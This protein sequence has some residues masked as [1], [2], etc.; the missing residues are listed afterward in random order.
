MF[1]K[2]QLKSL[3]VATALI[4]LNIAVMWI[5][6]FT[7]LAAIN[8][9]LFGS[10]FLLGVL[11]YGAMLTGGVH[12]AKKGVRNQNSSLAIGGT[13]LIQLAYGT[14]GAGIL[15]VF[16]S[17]QLQLIALAITGAVTTAIA[18]LSGLLVFGTNHD[19][20]GWGRYAN[21]IFLGVLGVSFIGSF[22]PTLTILAF[23]LALIGFVVYLI[24][25]IYVTKTRPETPFLNGIGLYTAYMGVF[26]EILQLVVRM[27]AEE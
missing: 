2:G 12:L 8:N 1:Q 10:F 7:D 27:L 26:V 25:E 21:Y 16:I 11:V 19:F 22:S 14:F 20:S 18:V 9:L 15:S 5:F 23:G 3:A 13:S 17:P 24:H 6:A 4:V